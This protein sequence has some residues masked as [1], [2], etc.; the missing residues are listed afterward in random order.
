MVRIFG[1]VAGCSLLAAGLVL[2][3]LGGIA[4]AIGGAVTIAASV[5]ASGILSVGGAGSIIMLVL[6]KRR[7]MVREYTEMLKLAIYEASLWSTKKSKN[8]QK[9]KLLP[10]APPDCKL[11]TTEL[12]SLLHEKGRHAQTQNLLYLNAFVL[13]IYFHYLSFLPSRYTESLWF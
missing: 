12:E 5:T 7:H 13:F 3:P 10:E 6:G 9:P 4:L 1:C 2:L 8:I 11:T